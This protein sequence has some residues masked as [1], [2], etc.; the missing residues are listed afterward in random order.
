M[1]TKSSNIKAFI[2]V[3]VLFIIFLLFRNDAERSLKNNGKIVNGRT[4]SWAIGSKS[5]N[6][7]Y[8]FEHEGK[9]EINAVA[10]EAIRGLKVF[11]NKSFPVLYEDG[12]GLSYIL[13]DPAD[14]KKYGITFP[15]SLN[16]VLPYFKK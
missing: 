14:F 9:L 3:G 5:Y 6:L 12:Y 11:E 1:K 8:E 13:I 15:D 4:L 16:W 7:Q 2:I 10:I